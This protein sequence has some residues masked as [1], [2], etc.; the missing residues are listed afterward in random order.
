MK[1]AVKF[2]LFFG[3]LTPFSPRAMI[4]RLLDKTTYRIL[5]VGCGRGRSILPIILRKKN[6]FRVG[7]D[8]FP[9]N[10]QFCK[11][12]GYYDDVILADVR[13]M[14]FKA[15]AFDAVLCIHVIEHLPKR[16]GL[17]MVQELEDVASKQVIAVTPVGFMVVDI[18][19]GNSWEIHRSGWMPVELESLGYE[20]RGI[21]PPRFLGRNYYLYYLSF[22]FPL[23]GLVFFN[24]KSA[25]E[26]ICTK[27][28]VREFENCG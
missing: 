17:S 9:S 7:L 11:L 8:I 15:N 3:Y 12:N 25:K 24:P 16:D 1:L 2:I 6:S 27:K 22:I 14:P 26:M 19:D 23:V 21:G 28:L 5:D 13:S 10:V 18:H 20:C 4:W